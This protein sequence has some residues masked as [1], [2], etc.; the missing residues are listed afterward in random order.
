MRPSWIFEESLPHPW[1]VVSLP[2]ERVYIIHLYVLL[3]LFSFL[4]VILYPY[5]LTQFLALVQAKRTL[6]CVLFNLRIGTRL[7]N[8]NLHK[9]LILNALRARGSNLCKVLT[10]NGLGRFYLVEFVA[11]GKRRFSVQRVG[12]LTCPAHNKRKLSGDE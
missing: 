2:F 4:V 1:Q 7:A 3:I 6:F 8:G 12:D 10:L 5:I 9:L 11:K